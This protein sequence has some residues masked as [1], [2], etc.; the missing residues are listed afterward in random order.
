VD[1]MDGHFV[2]NITIGPVVVK[3]LKKHTQLPL[4]VHLMI[5]DPMK[6]AEPFAK[7]GGDTL[8]FH[9]EAVEDP[10]RV[11][12]R[13]HELGAGAGVALRPRTPFDQV[14]PFLRDLEQVLIMSVEPGFSGQAFIPSVLPKVAAA[15]SALERMGSRADVSIDG[16]ITVETAPGAAAHGASFF[17][18]GNS[19]FVGGEIQENLRRLRQAVDEGARRAL[20]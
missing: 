2:P 8:V 7:A 6:Y 5:T 19:V 14:E 11:I 3:S 1:V 12:R 18:C 9:R 17:V 10:G 16:G 15:R 20:P 4:D 13:I